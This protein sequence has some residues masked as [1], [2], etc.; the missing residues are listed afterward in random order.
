[1]TAAARMLPMALA[2]PLGPPSVRLLVGGALAVAVAAAGVDPAG[3]AAAAGPSGPAGPA[4]IAWLLGEALVGALLG[5]TVQVVVRAAEGA[6][7]LVDAQR[8]SAVARRSDGG[9]LELAFRLLALSLFAALGGPVLLVDG[10]GRTYQALPPGAVAGLGARG[11]AALLDVGAAVM[12]VTLEV[13]APVALALWLGDLALG[14]LRRAGPGLLAGVGA[15]GGAAVRELLA[16]VAVLGGSGAVVA[17][18]AARV[19]TLADSMMAA[20]R[21]ITG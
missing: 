19:P 17:A 4:G 8:R 7:A 1:V 12:A 5:G 6:G 3:P 15:P 11:A 20:A 18:L 13:A 9:G 21:T 16:V 14:L 10:V 2:A